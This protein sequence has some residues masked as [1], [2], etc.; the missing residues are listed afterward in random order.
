[1]PW[2]EAWAL[3]SCGE[4][5][6]TSSDASWLE[7]YNNK[8]SKA[9]W[10]ILDHKKHNLIIPIVGKKTSKEMFDAIVTLYESE[11]K[12]KQQQQEFAK[13]V[14]ASAGANELDSILETTFSLVAC[15]STNA[16]SSVGWCVD[17]RASRHMTLEKKDFGRLQ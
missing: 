2:E 7:K 4:E 13:S 9:K 5:S 8:T 15:F 16:F 6:H 1:M 14:E 17:N 11:K 12:A 3:T 10:A